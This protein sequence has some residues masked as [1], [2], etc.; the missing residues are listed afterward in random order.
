MDARAFEQYI[1]NLRS[2]RAALRERLKSVDK[3]LFEVENKLKMAEAVLDDF[4]KE[5]ELPTPPV[6]ID[7]QLHRKFAELS[8]KEMLIIIAFEAGGVLDITEARTIL[9]KAGVF[10]NERN[11]VTSMSPILSRHD[12]IFKR[13]SRGTYHLEPTS[14]NDKERALLARISTPALNASRI[15][16]LGTVITR[17][18]DLLQRASSRY[19]AQSDSK[20]PT[21]KE[22]LL[23]IESELIDDVLTLLRELDQPVPS[24][25][26]AVIL[27]Q[28]KSYPVE[29]KL[30]AANLFS[31]KFGKPA[32]DM[33]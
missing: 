1:E 18:G 31:Q 16:G 12:D 29:V 8:I 13:T 21:P 33:S 25:R 32:P 4:C 11:A 3:E 19:G 15:D 5:F 30:Q 10:Q 26:K 2:K 20:S 23:K 22:V 17:A 6:A 14:L 9:L 28:L 7:S 24:D 27:S